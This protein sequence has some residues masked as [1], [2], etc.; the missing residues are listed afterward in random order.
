MDRLVSGETSTEGTAAG[1]VSYPEEAPKP[2][3]E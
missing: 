1:S 2:D 3:D